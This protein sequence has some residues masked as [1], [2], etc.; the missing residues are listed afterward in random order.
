[1]PTGI[2]H[3]SRGFRNRIRGLSMEADCRRTMADT[4]SRLASRPSQGRGTPCRRR[5]RGIET[6]CRSRTAVP[7]S[8]ARC[9]TAGAAHQPKAEVKMKSGSQYPE[10]EPEQMAQPLLTVALVQFVEVDG[11]P[12]NA[13]PENLLDQRPLAPWPRPRQ[14]SSAWCTPMSRCRCSAGELQND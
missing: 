1:M 5:T 13:Q 9:Q 11:W 2:R 8:E 10:R 14:R 4:P 6:V 7:P 3:F 12:L